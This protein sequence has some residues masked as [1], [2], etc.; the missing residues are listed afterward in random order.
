MILNET[1]NYTLQTTI[2]YLDLKTEKRENLN[3][4]MDFEVCSSSQYDKD[5]YPYLIKLSKYNPYDAH[6]NM[7]K[8]YPLIN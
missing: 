7:G 4:Y 1:G 8:K 3:F 6:W 5:E 2:Y